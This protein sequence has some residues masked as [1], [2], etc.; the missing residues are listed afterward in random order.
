MN[1]VRQLQQLFCHVMNS[2]KLDILLHSLHWSIHTKD[3]SF[4]VFFHERKCNGM[5]SFMEFMIGVVCVKVVKCFGFIWMSSSITVKFAQFA[6]PLYMVNSFVLSIKYYLHK[7]RDMVIYTQSLLCN[8]YH[9]MGI[10]HVQHAF[11]SPHMSRNVCS[12]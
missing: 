9:L 12:H 2:M 5:T 10:T 1:F 7:C 4:G 6:D 3:E 11:M 8:M